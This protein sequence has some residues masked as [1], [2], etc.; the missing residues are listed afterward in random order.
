MFLSLKQ[1]MPF[2]GGVRRDKIEIPK[3]PNFVPRFLIC[4]NSIE[5][6]RRTRMRGLSL[7]EIP[8]FLLL[9]S[10]LRHIT[11]FNHIEKQLQTPHSLYS[12][13]LSSFVSLHACSPCVRRTVVS[14][15]VKLMCN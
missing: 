1:I 7:L 5:L 2:E 14:I 13:T 11:T 8:G 12:H 6:I 10:G 4:K 15:E 9:F 3:Q